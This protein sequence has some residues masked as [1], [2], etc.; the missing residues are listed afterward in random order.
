MIGPTYNTQGE[1]LKTK[2]K[3]MGLLPLWIW[4]SGPGSIGSNS[5]GHMNHW[6]TIPM[7]PRPQLTRAEQEFLQAWIWEEAHPQEPNASSAK[8]TQIANNPYAA[9]VLA[10]IAAATMTAEE[11]LDAANGP[12]PTGGASWPWPTE[13]DLRVR[14]RQARAWLENSRTSRQAFPTASR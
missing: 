11:Q 12:A 10:D 2:N 3:R 6:R 9:P 14:H 5:L 8:K 13:E 4:K 1:P 7:H